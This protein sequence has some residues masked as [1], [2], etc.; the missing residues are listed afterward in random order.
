MADSSFRLST[1]QVVLMT[2]DKALCRAWV[3]ADGCPG[4]NNRSAPDLLGIEARQQAW[5]SAA[6]V[7]DRILTDL[8]AS[9]QSSLPHELFTP[10]GGIIGLTEILNM[11][12]SSFDTQQ[13][14]LPDIHRI[15]RG[16]RTPEIISGYTRSGG[17]A[18]GVTCY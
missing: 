15:Q 14:I 5:V 3:G 6:Q 8:R 10:L 7:E 12:L 1:R 9:L 13:G 11:G 18:C 16:Y 2:E 4:Q 17:F